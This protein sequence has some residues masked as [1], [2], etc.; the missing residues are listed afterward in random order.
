MMM[1]V[2]ELSPFVLRSLNG[3]PQTIEG[4]AMTFAEPSFDTDLGVEGFEPTEAETLNIAAEVDRIRPL[5]KN[6]QLRS[7]TST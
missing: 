1:P 2:S 5:M 7:Y 4:L 3:K 6:S